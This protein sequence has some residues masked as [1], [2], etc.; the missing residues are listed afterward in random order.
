MPGIRCPKCGLVQ[1]AKGNCKKCGAPLSISP[2]PGGTSDHPYTPPARPTAA[3]P[4]ASRSEGAYDNVFDRDKFLLRQRALTIGEKYEVWDE[5]GQPILFVE[6]P[7]HALRNLGAL[8]AGLAAGA[9]IG[10]PLMWLSDRFESVALSILAIVCGLIAVFVVAVALQRKRHIHFY[11]D[12]SK[13]EELLQVLQDQKLAGLTHTY[14]VNDAAGRSLARLSKNL[15]TDL[16]RKQW[17][18]MSADGQLLWVAKEDSIVLAI[19]R[20]L[21]GL[22]PLHFVFCAPEGGAPLG[23]FNRKFTLLDRYVL[24]LS[25]DPGRMLDRRVA[26]AMGVM[27]D[28][29]ER[30]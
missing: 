18:C 27:L 30:R 26:L 28:T 1:L 5:Q 15:L 19:L 8:F 6:R 23:Q 17:R 12:D 10:A 3:L 14:T 20:R 11:R 16:F 4:R 25:A 9:A 13:R 24:D 21:T 22:V 7:A 29:G 2:A